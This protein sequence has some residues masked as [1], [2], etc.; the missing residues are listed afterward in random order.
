M[1]VNS[2]TNSVSEAPT[3]RKAGA[4]L[5]VVLVILCLLSG[6]LFFGFLSA[7]PLFRGLFAHMGADLPVATQMIIDFSPTVKI[8]LSIAWA[9]QFLLTAV[10]VIAKGRMAAEVTLVVA[11][12]NVI[13]GAAF[14]GCLYLPIWAISF[15]A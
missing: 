4:L 8:P 15:A 12:L 13:S 7:A 1:P 6:V 10:S 5:R 11:I 9:A 2:S 14:V 3:A